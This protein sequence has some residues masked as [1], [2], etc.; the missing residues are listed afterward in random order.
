MRISYW[1]S[2]VC[3]SDRMRAVHRGVRRGGVG[4]IVG[5]DIGALGTNGVNLFPRYAPRHQVTAGAVGVG[6]RCERCYQCMSHDPPHVVLNNR[7]VSAAR[8]ALMAASIAGLTALIDLGSERTGI[9]QPGGSAV[10]GGP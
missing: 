9:V 3:S 10:G 6:Q 4:R 2:V 8:V 7:A 5:M 1:S